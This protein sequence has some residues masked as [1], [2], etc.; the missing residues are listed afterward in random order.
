M[1]REYDNNPFVWGITGGIG[2]GKSYVCRKLS[3]RGWPVFYCD[4][5]AKRLIRHDAKLKQQLVALVGAELYGADGE[6]NKA[7]MAAFL[8]RGTHY[9]SLVDSVVHPCVAEA[10]LLWKHKQKNPMV[11]MECALL[12]EAGFD[13]LVDRSVHVA[14]SHATQLRR[15]MERDGV[16]EGQAEAWMALQMPE[17]EKRRRADVVLYNDGDGLTEDE[18]VRIFGH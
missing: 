12:F 10:F 7:V 16:T 13:S 1:C 18:L 11:V 2:S 5:E 14:V 4:D 8:C 3:E 9:A 15:V 17:E 6:L